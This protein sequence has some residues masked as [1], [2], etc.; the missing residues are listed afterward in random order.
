VVAIAFPE[1]SSSILK[2]H[3][4][5][6]DFDFFFFFESNRVNTDEVAIPGSMVLAI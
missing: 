1:A 2:H 6:E 4:A 3:P 5:E